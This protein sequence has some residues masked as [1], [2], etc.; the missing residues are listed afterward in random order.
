M[1]GAKNP[2]RAKFWFLKT[3]NETIIGVWSSSHPQNLTA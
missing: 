1:H 3:S 2:K